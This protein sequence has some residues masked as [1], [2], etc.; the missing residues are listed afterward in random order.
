MKVCSLLNKLNIAA[1]WLLPRT[2]SYGEWVASGEIDLM[3]SRGNKELVLDGLNI[4]NKLSTST[5]HWGPDSS[6]NRYRK[7]H[8]EK[9][10]ENGF[11]KKFHKYQLIWTTAYIQFLIDDKEIGK[12]TPPAGGFWEM[13]AFDEAYYNPW[14]G[15]S[16]IAPFDQE[17][18]ILI[19]LAV[20][21]ISYFPDAAM[22][23]AKKP[24]ENDSKKVRTD[25]CF[26][27]I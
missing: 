9:T 8:W 6:Q 5:L 27:R 3:E 18:F 21:G 14:V 1:I 24:W 19:N 26:S 23:P 10:N 13:G 11:D 17:F 22:N 2:N 15:R 16:K 20:G 4:G 12:V 25:F 7:T